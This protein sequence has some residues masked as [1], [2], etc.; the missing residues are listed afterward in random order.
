[1][2]DS[3]VSAKELALKRKPRFADESATY[4]KAREALLVEEL[5]VRRHVGRLARQNRELPEGPEM[6]DKSIRALR[7]AGLRIRL[8]AGSSS[9]CPSPPTKSGRR[10]GIA[11]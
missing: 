1:M 11:S 4:A 6:P 2:A 7:G 9:A 3:L 5:E 10:F 8:G